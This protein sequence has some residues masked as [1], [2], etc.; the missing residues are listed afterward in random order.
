[1]VSVGFCVFYANA[2]ISSSMEIKKQQENIQTLRSKQEGLVKRLVSL[3]SIQR[4][5]DEVKVSDMV[6]VKT[7]DYIIIPQE[8]FAKK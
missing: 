6:E 4:V 8:T 2:G 1:M 5:Y 7:A 3:S